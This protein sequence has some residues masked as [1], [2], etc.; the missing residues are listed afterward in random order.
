M[1]IADYTVASLQ[2]L[3]ITLRILRDKGVL[4][5]NDIREIIADLEAKAKSSKNA[6]SSG[7]LDVA[8]KFRSDLGILD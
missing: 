7:L 6:D 5:D 4:S 2:T 1:T 8:A 3:A